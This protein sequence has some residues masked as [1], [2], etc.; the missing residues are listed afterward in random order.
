MN[1]FAQTSEPFI[2]WGW[3][4]DHLD[5]VWDRTVE[6]L[7]LTAVAVLAGLAISSVLAAIA[8]RFRRTYSPI[9]WFSGLLYTI[10]SLALFG[11]L[12]PYTGL[13][14]LTAEIALTSY[15]IL[16]LVRNI[17]AGFDGVPAEVREAATGM[18]Y[19]PLRRVLTIELPLAAP[20]IIA[21]I[22]IASVTV[23]GLVTVTA[24]IG[25]GGYGAFILDGLNREFPTPIVL[26]TVLSVVLAVVLDLFLVLAER[27]LTPWRRGSARP[28]TVDR[29]LR[30][31][32][33]R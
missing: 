33:L 4:G 24:L 25:Y 11:F 15:T 20:T 8:I 21:G 23:V 27:A 10:P 30:P 31:V 7:Q 17:V 14:F 22:R 16:I 19:T 13:S 12:I 18:G 3:I 26:G 5:D 32:T 29:D 28:L 1:V 6:H 2:R 9:T